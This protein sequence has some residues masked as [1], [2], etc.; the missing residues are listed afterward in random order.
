MK[1]RARVIL[2]LA[3]GFSLL[4]SVAPAMAEV[5][6]TKPVKIVVGFPP[7]GA[8]DT[9]AR[10][11]AQKLAERVGQPVVVEN[12][13]GAD[14]IIATEYVARSAPDGHTLLTGASGQ[15]TFNPLLQAKLPY[16]PMKDFT[17]ITML[18]A[19]PL[20]IAVNPSLPAN[21]LK[22][23]IA[24]A[25][26]KPG[27]LF[28]A[29]AAPPFYVALEEFKRLANVNIVNVP[30]KGSGQAIVGAISGD[31]P[32]IMLTA[33]SLLTQIKAGKLRPLAVTGDKR[34]PAVP[35]T[36]TMAELGMPM[37]GA[38]W[39]GLFVPSATPRPVVDKIYSELAAVLKSDYMR[40]KVAAAG[41]GTAVLGVTPAEFEAFHKSE[42]AH[43]SKVVKDLKLGAK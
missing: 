31:A 22:E 25:R 41:Y 17:P 4:F 26:A 37:R 6:P 15:M 33:G 2:A 18:Y 23:L 28:Y 30:Y 29:S 38:S 16:D 39:S 40:E 24:L 1:S 42:F 11:V 32:M 14:G 19:D 34:D 20:V 8:N 9:V 13:P 43:W 35:D 27:S 3:T 36:P 12:K 7:G 10:L 5:W 21:S